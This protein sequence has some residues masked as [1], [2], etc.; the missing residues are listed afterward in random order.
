MPVQWHPATSRRVSPWEKSPEKSEVD[1]TNRLPKESLRDGSGNDHEPLQQPGHLMTALPE[2]RPMGAESTTPLITVVICTHNR[3]ALLEKAVRSVLAQMEAAAEVLIV[4]NA[5][6]DATPAVAG[7]LARNHSGV[8]VWREPELG[9][10]AARNAAL[11]LAHGPYVLFLDDDAVAEPGWLAAYVR[12]LSAPPT[13]RIAVVGG[14]VIPN[15]EVPPPRWLMRRTYA[16]DRGEAPR[17]LKAK[18]GPWGCNVAYART[19][20]LHVGAFNPQLGRKGKTFL[21]HEE[22]ELNARLEKAGHE[23]WWL[24]AARIF[25][26]VPAKRL[27]FMWLCHTAFTEGRSTAVFRLNGIEARWRRVGYLLGR[28]AAAPVQSL[29]L[30]LVAAVCCPFQEGQRSARAIFQAARSAGVGSQMALE[31]GRAVRGHV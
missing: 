19:A 13:P 7:Q 17:L 4:D 15:F 26:W 5:S 23:I 14:G 25:H 12:F 20:A 30:L 2:A 24:P 28:A 27:K 31:L 16:L 8:R 1:M 21:A 9:L 29:L 11:R 22:S 6:S 3:A 18:G 10:S